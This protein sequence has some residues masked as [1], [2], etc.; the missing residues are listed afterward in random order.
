MFNARAGVLFAPLGGNDVLDARAVAE[1]LLEGHVGR[2]ELVRAA[3]GEARALEAE[4]INGL[5]AL[6]LAAA[7]LEAREGHEERLVALLG[8]QLVHAAL[9]DAAR[10][11]ALAVALLPARVAQ[12]GRLRR[13]AGHEALH[14]AA[15]AVDAPLALLE[16]DVGQPG[17]LV[18][19]PVH[20]AL[21]EHARAVEVAED[22]LEV[23]VLEPERLDARQQAHGAVPHVARA[24]HEARA[25]LHL[26]EADPDVR[27]LVVHVE[28]ALVDG[29]RAP[30]PS[31]PPPTWR[32]AATPPR[33]CGSCAAG[34][35]TP[36]AS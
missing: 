35:R 30:S 34:P 12:V 10:Q 5:G 18:G 13:P 32:S 23:R 14:H 33:C 2:V 25:Q 24:V 9:E 29:A 3:R 1:L 17:L 36:C 8:A 26:G 16:L 7:R 19:L 28:R 11:R 21:E 6:E 4:G 15:R 31:G 27:R 22:L 20:P